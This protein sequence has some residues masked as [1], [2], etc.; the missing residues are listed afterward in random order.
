VTQ[1]ARRA[2]PGTRSSAGQLHSIGEVLA[3]LKPEFGDLTHSKLRFLEDRG[4]VTPE[5]TPSGYR[6]FTGE[7]VERLR[8]VLALQRNHYMPLKAIAE[9]L[10]AVDRGLEPPELP[11]G[12]PQVPRVVHD[13][14]GPGPESFNGAPRDL[15]LRREEL[16]EAAGAEPELINALEGY[17]LVSPGPSGYFDASAVEVARTARELADYGIEPRHLRAFRTAAERELGLVEQVVAPLRHHRGAGSPARADEVAREIS[18]LCVR[19]HT[20]LVRA[21]LDRLGG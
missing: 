5:R 17:G 16:A 4:L 1:A 8:L 21:G 20:G 12:R 19:L 18:S 11:G 15:R 7:D 9:Y 14:A 2:D 6:K 3:E 10:D 13:A